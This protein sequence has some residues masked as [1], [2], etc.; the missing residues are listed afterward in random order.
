MIA[1]PVIVRVLR[2]PQSA[3]G[4][5]LAEWDLL[6]RQARASNLLARLAWLLQQEGIGEQVPERVAI[7]LEG[8]TVVAARHRLAVNWE[9]GHIGRALASAGLP[10]ILLKG[11]AYVAAD[12]PAARGRT[13]S[14]IDI[15]VPKERINEA[16]A[17]MMLHGWAA[18]HHDEYDQ[19]Y[20]REWMHELPP[21][22]HGQRMTVVD[23]HHAILPETAASK[24]DSAK[25]IAA[26]IAVPGRPGVHVLQ[27]TDMVIHSACHLFHEEELDKGLRDL[28]DLDALLRHFAGQPD[29]WPQLTRRASE[30]DLA[31]PLFYALRYT[32]ALLDTPVPAAAIREIAAS[33]PPSL[34][35]AGMDALYRRALLPRHDSCRDWLTDASRRALFVRAH[36]LRMPPILLVRHLMHKAAT[37][38]M[39][40]PGK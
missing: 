6:L 36:W 1:R 10:L 8:A 26:S 35:L 2:D 29:F 32:R 14:D 5:S 18:T 31:R 39:G 17:A 9:I 28:A 30:L 21:M 40:P 25:L 12:L 34:L 20:Y 38:I 33:G 27:P 37:G 11:A 15:L 19:R 16:E 4:L 24:P 23:V 13:F 22:Q 3:R 7:H